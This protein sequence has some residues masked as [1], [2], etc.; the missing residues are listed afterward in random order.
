MLQTDLPEI[1][2]KAHAL[3]TDAGPK[4]ESAAMST[5]N[6]SNSDTQG[7]DIGKPHAH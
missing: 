2:T 7:E 1:H 6:L 3:K 4:V 5:A